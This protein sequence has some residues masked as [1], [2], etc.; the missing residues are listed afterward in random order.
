VLPS[1]TN[2]SQRCR[3]VSAGRPAALD[4]AIAAYDVLSRVI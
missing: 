3:L 2:L 4:F 1:T